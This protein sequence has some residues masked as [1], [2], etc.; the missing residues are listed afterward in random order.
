MIPVSSFIKF[1]SQIPGPVE[2]PVSDILR[3][4]KRHKIP[5]VLVFH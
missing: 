4:V 5:E 2:A 1:N 3:A